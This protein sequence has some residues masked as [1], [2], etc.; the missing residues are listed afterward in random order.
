MIKRMRQY[1]DADLHETIDDIASGPPDEDIIEEEPVDLKDEC[2]IFPNEGIIDR[3][4]DDDTTHAQRDKGAMLA[5]PPE[6]TS[7]HENEANSS[8]SMMKMKS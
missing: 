6:L 3:A 8:P 4:A 1:L 2:S 7:I 5:S